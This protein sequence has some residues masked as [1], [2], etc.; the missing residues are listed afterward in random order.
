MARVRAGLFGALSFAL[1]LTPPLAGSALVFTPSPAH[2]D[3]DPRKKAAESTFQEGVRLQAQGKSEEALAKFKKAYDM[4]PSP[5]TLGGIAR[6]EQALGRNLEALRHYREALRNPL[7]HPENAEH[8]G[9]AIKGLEKDLARVDVKGPKG[10]AVIIDGTEYV[11]PLAEPVDIK[12]QTLELTATFGGTKYAGRATAAIGRV[13]DLEMTAQPAP[14]PGA[15]LVPPSHATEGTPYSPPAPSRS[16]WDA[17][18]VTGI[19]L[20]GV[21]LGGVGAGALFSA[22]SSSAADRASALQTRLGRDACTGSA[23]PPECADLRT[24]RADQDRSSTLS[25]AFVV[26]GAVFAV[27]GATF[28][29]WPRSDVRVTPSATAN[30]GSL[31]MTG[32]F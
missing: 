29:F 23:A 11:L 2:A 26:G 28:F 20:F 31:L 5:N 7:L 8:V 18:R 4:Y 9:A 32:S 24:A 19:V 21:G 25:T 6:V 22:S 16:F 27:A 1:A 17:G 14:G 12:A 30:G 10:L 13:T 3:D 15:A